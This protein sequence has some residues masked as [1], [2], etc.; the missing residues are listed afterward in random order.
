MSVK[1]KVVKHHIKMLS[2]EGPLL[3]VCKLSPA[4]CADD[5]GREGY[6]AQ[7]ME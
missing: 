7:N 1:H 5:E 2:T 4:L 3:C 6:I